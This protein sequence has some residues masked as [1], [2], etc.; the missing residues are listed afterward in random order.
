MAVLGVGDPWLAWGTMLAALVLVAAGAWVLMRIVVRMT[1]RTKGD[2]DDRVLAVV[3]RP[4]AFFL[5]LVAAGAV[6]VRVASRLGPAELQWTQRFLAALAIGTAAWV[7][8]GVVRL[9][10]E[11]AGKKRPR[12]L[13]ATHV[14]RRLLAVIVYTAAFL[15]VLQ[16]FGIAITPLLTGLGIA[17]LAA[18]LALQDTL[19]NFFA[20][21]S[22]QTGRALQPGHFVR[23][24]DKKLEGY[25]S[26]V[27]WRTTAIRTL[28]GNTIVIPNAELAQAVITDFYLPAPD[29]G[30]GIDVLV[31]FDADPARVMEILVEEA[32]E[33]QKANDGVVKDQPP[34]AR[35]A[36]IEP[37]ALRFNV[38]I[39]LKEYVAQYSVQQDLLL[40]IVARFR[41]EGIRIPYPT[42]HQYDQRVTP[43]ALRTHGALGGFASD[44]SGR[45]PPR[46]PT[47]PSAPETQDP[48]EAEAAKARGEIAA[49]QAQDATKDAGKGAPA[50]DRPPEASAEA[51]S[52]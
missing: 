50:Q 7:L 26:E 10:L 30:F 22:I 23:V 16:Q 51:K 6:L 28:A 40:R 36:A 15:M 19:S 5:G 46:P 52:P 34:H 31:N 37:Y 25:V 1:A 45:R 24:E 14:G 38:S 33:V 4:F 12:I 21:I 2:F 48:L 17:G 39:R 20:G 35:L 42:S 8:V 32:R 43:E 27:G 41:R 47:T 29:L 13:P 9:L 44:R 18:A 49:K 11:A 3:H